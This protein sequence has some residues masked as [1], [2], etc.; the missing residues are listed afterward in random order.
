M[1]Y[2]HSRVTPTTLSHYLLHLMLMQI[3]LLVPSTIQMLPLWISTDILAMAMA[4]GTHAVV[5][6]NCSRVCNMPNLLS[7]P[8]TRQCGDRISRHAVSI[9]GISDT[10]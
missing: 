6:T 2:W 3:H 1:S 5:S 8:L 10:A 7:P 9:A 4:H